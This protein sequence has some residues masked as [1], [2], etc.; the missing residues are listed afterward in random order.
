M[1]D[2]GIGSLHQRDVNRLRRSWQSSVVLGSG[3]LA[4]N[5]NSFV[6]Q[7]QEQDGQ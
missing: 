1:R 5:S 7:Q 4:L 6:V 3:L 2:V